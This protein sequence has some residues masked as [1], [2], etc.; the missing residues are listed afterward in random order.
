VFSFSLLRVVGIFQDC[1]DVVRHSNQSHE[2]P[3]L[4]GIKVVQ[5]CPVPH[6]LPERQFRG[7]LMTALCLGKFNRV[8]IDRAI[9]RV[10]KDV[11]VSLHGSVTGAKGLLTGYIGEEVFHDYLET[12]CGIPLHHIDDHNFDFQ[13]DNG[14]KIEVKTA[15]RQ[16]RPK[17]KFHNCVGIL[18]DKQACDVYVFL[19]IQWIV[20]WKL[21]YLWFC[22][23]V[24]KKEF[25][26][27][28]TIHKAGTTR[29]GSSF[30]PNTTLRTISIG[31][32]GPIEELL[33][34]CQLPPA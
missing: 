9:R 7:F 18:H 14:L 26:Q 4:V 24:S 21:G 13:S 10:E 30:V 3:A 31:E 29:P 8:P 20:E 28:S 15:Q 32:C 23:T 33:E 2:L 16:S 12:A 25:M 11:R 17:S 22:G 1:L 34:K 5:C 6:K 19:Q 27:Q